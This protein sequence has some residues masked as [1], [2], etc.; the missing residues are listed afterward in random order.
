MWN[1]QLELSSAYAQLPTP[2]STGEPKFTTFHSGTKST[3]DYIWYSRQSLHCHGVAEMTPAGVLF[4]QRELPTVH[5][6]S[7]HLSLVA[8]FSLRATHGSTVG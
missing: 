6:P 5:H 1:T 4:K 7:D 3:V 8:N 2:Q